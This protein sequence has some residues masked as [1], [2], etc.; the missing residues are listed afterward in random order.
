[1]T[2]SNGRV[3]YYRDPGAPRP[4]VVV[5]LVYAVV[6]DSAGRVLLVRRLD[7]GD[8]ELPGGRVEPGESATDALV[9]EV[10]EETGLLVDVQRVAGVY[11][12]PGHVVRTGRD[13][14]I[15]QPFAVCFHATA[16]PGTPRPDLV[17]TCEV[18]WWPVD[19][20][21]H[22]SVQPAVRRRLRDALFTPERVHVR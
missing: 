16:H 5:P 15:R 2:H 4:T 14:E 21:D 20:L 9:R 12:D 11:S 6:R 3:E 1:M 17:E 22:L 18:N 19:D 7:T 13:G 8:W 10:A